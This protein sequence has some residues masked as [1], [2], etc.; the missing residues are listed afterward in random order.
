MVISLHIVVTIITAIC[1]FYYFNNFSKFSGIQ[2]YNT[3]NFVKNNTSINNAC[4]GFNP[5]QL[6]IDICNIDR[7][8]NISVTEFISN[9][10]NKKPVIL[11]NISNNNEFESM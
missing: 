11:L 9:Y 8:S 2:A 6:D 1:L 7:G 10:M 3:Q 4:Q 5:I